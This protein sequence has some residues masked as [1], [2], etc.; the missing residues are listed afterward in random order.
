[1]LAARPRLPF[2][3]AMLLPLLLALGGCANG[4]A[5]GEGVGAMRASLAQT[6]SGTD[7]TFTDINAARRDFAVHDLI[8]AKRAPTEA[9]FA[10]VIDADTIARWDAAFARLDD[11]LGALQDLVG[12]RQSDQTRAN[13][14]AVG[15]GLTSGKIG[16]TLPRGT[17]DLFASLGSALVEAAASKRALD[18]MQRTDPQV[19]AL[20]RKMAD[21]VYGPG[22]E[23]LSAPVRTQWQRRLRDISANEYGKVANGSADERA[24]VI[25]SYGKAYD[26][27]TAKLAALAGLR[28]GLLALGEAHAAAAKGND[29]ALLYWIG[30]IDDRL[31]AVRKSIDSGETDS[32]GG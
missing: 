18:I 10:P 19:Q 23:T 27:R 17:A 1:M 24:A 15:T 8:E 12:T 26:E 5:I 32:N 29:N 7:N 22:N 31:K 9:D 11:Y 28:D 20:T 14:M 16:A 21:L 2:R 25:E 4:P 30:Q 6:R 3:L 13:I